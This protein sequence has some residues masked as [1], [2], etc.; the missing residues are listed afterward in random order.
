MISTRGRALIGERREPRG[1]GRRHIDGCRGSRYDTIRGARGGLHAV[2][3]TC[4]DGAGNQ[5]QGSVTFSLAA[6]VPGTVF[7]LRWWRGSPSSR[8]PSCSSRSCTGAEGGRR[9]ASK[10]RTR[11]R[12]K[13]GGGSRGRGGRVRTVVRRLLGKPIYRDPDISSGVPVFRRGG[14]GGGGGGAACFFLW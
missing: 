13:E 2:V 8:A 11:P 4:R 12:R 7:R 6:A 14:G 10:T 3:I 9:R 5:G 1:P